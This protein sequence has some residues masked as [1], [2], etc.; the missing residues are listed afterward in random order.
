MAGEAS[1]AGHGSI[2][3]TNIC[4]ETPVK[5]RQCR[6]GES[7]VVIS[8]YPNFGANKRYKWLAIPLLPFLYGVEDERNIPI[9]TNG[10]IR[11]LLRESYRQRN[12][13]GMI[14][15][16]IGGMIPEGDWRE[17]LTSVYNRDIY[18]FTLRTSVEEDKILI[19]KLNSEPNVN[20]FSSMY[21]NCA[22]FARVV[23]NTYFTHATHRDP[24]NDLT[25]TTPKAIAQTLTRYAAKHP[26][27]L[28]NISKYSQLAGPIRR[29]MDNRH[30]SEQALFSKKYLLPQLLFNHIPIAFF[31]VAYLTTGY[32][33][34]HRKYVEYA[35]PEIAQINL[36]AKR[37]KM[38]RLERD[39][40]LA[41][42]GTEVAGTGGGGDSPAGMTGIE[43]MKEAERRRIFGT[44]EIWAKYRKEFAPLKQKAINDGLFADE[45]EVRTFFR[46]LE[47]QSIPMF[48][49]Q[50]RLMLK[51]RAYGQEKYL[52]L[53]RENILG[54]RSDQQLAFKLMIA[55]VNAT[56]K[57]KEKNR[58]SLETFT[59]DWDLL[60]KL[61]AASYPITH[62]RNQRFLETP[63]KTTFKHKLKMAFVLITH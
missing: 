23:L 31:S 54:S 32:F 48:D 42:L 18:C 3:F 49:E 30:Y 34:V 50:G 26:E 44:S 36:A 39:R 45:K 51:V 35:T 47:L 13:R 1:S 8:T 59:A 29:S 22:D 7:G 21:N 6:P 9:Y 60:K 63:E 4:A 43:R 61:S 28:F 62:S 52:G 24:I 25:M 53:T 27:R 16:G 10:M 20:N 19:D 55:R 37:L 14:P 41:R 38:N 12:L 15:D 2:Y 57:A 40:A 58:E 33:S 46:D 17:M 56:F 5:L 11:S